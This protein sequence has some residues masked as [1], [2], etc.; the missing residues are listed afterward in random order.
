MIIAY[1][2]VMKF[3]RSYLLF[4]L[5]GMGYLQQFYRHFE[6]Y[7]PGIVLSETDYID[8]A[9]NGF[10]V[11]YFPDGYKR[12]VTVFKDDYRQGYYCS[13]YPT[14]FWR[15]QQN[16]SIGFIRRLNTDEEFREKVIWNQF[17]FKG[18]TIRTEGF[19]D[20]GL[21]SGKWT[22][23]NEQS[24][25]TG[26]RHYAKGKLHGE[27]SLYKYDSLSA[28]NHC[29]F[30]GK[31]ANGLAEGLQS[32]YAVNGDSS[33]QYFH[34]GLL[35]SALKY[36][37]GKLISIHYYS[38]YRNG[39]KRLET[40]VRLS[41]AFSIAYDTNGVAGNVIQSPSVPSY[42]MNMLKKHGANTDPDAFNVYDVAAKYPGG[43]VHLKED[44]IRALQKEFQLQGINPPVKLL[45]RLQV[46]SNGRVSKV[47]ALK[48]TPIECRAVVKS[49]EWNLKAFVPASLNGVPVASYVLVEVEF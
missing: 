7:A 14:S 15:A 36:E 16:D 24:M 42:Q 29:M 9:K 47:H 25:V 11:H 45:L 18:S 4:G 37:G 35:D 33:L 34:A 21:Q 27:V 8:S 49:M 32:I 41:G 23:Y 43:E 22:S 26:I 10:E 17:L 6:F 3:W 44:L 13:F 46:E 1:F 2:V 30:R 31:Y 48:A 5:C 20:Q 39:Q 12:S 40:D 28:Q 38:Y 19:Y